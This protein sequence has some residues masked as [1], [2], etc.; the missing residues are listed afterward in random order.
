MRVQGCRRVFGSWGVEIFFVQGVQT[1][2]SPVSH[3]FDLEGIQGPKTR[4]P[5]IKIQIQIQNLNDFNI[6]KKI[7]NNNF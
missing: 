4:D 2:K 6:D 5:F 7:K 1:F 3:A